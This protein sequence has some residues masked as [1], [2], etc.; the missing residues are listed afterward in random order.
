[1]MVSQEQSD[2]VMSKYHKLAHTITSGV[3]VKSKIFNTN[4][5]TDYKIKK[6]NYIL[7]LGRLVPEKKAETLIQGF[8]EAGCQNLQL[9]IFNQK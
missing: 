3:Y 2:Y 6:N 1:M 5:L 7:Y 4:I 9:I 8:I